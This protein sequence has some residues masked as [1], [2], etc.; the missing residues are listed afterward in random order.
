M[1][2]IFH[3]LVK[4]SRVAILK[5]ILFEWYCNRCIYITIIILFPYVIYVFLCLSFPSFCCNRTTVLQPYSNRTLTVLQPYSNRTAT[6]LPYSNRTATVQQPYCN[7]TA[8][9]L[10]PYCNRTATVCQPYSNRT[11]TVQRNSYVFFKQYS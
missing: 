4:T 10:Q 1:G 11:A 8:T 2:V 5:K 6:V 7:R 9:V 3:D